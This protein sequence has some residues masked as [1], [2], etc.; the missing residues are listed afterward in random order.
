MESLMYVSKR[1]SNSLTWLLLSLWDIPQQAAHR[2]RE[3]WKPINSAQW[4][5]FHQFS[6]RFVVLDRGSSN[7][8]CRNPLHACVSAYTV[9]QLSISLFSVFLQTRRNKKQRKMIWHTFTKQQM[10]FETRISLLILN[11][12]N[13]GFLW[14]SSVESFR[15]YSFFSPLWWNLISRDSDVPNRPQAV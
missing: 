10:I 14:V 8:L 15:V 6:S 12:P 7:Q 4:W 2:G 1:R 5:I 9:L 11:V 13:V 3:A